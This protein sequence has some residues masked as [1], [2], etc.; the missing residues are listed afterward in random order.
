M[1]CSTFAL[2]ARMPDP[3]SL[4]AALHAG[5]PDLRVDRAGQGAVVRLCTEEGRQ[6]VAV[7]APRYLQVP[8]EA[9]RLLGPAAATESPVWWTEVRAASAVP[10]A[11]RLSASVA[12]RL[13]SLLD[14]TT[15]PRETAAHTDVVTV[16]ASGEPAPALA[17][18]D[19][20]LTEAD[21]LTDR[22]AIVLPDI[23]VL[24]ATTWLTELLRT[25]ARTGRHLYLVTPP[26]TRLTLPARTLLDRAP[27]RWVVRDPGTG[28][29]D[30]LT[31]LEL[32][33]HG[34]HFAPPAGRNPTVVD[35]YR[36]PPTG[37][38]GERQFLLSARTIHPAD[39]QLLLGGTLECAWQTLTG[40]PPAGW[41]TAEP[42]NVPWSRRQLTDLARSRA[43]RGS[44][45]WL[46]AV[47]SPGRPAIAT[48]WV[49]HT[50]LGVEE[51]ITLALGHTADS[52]VPLDRLPH[53]AEVLAAQH[54]LATM[55]TEV[56]AARADLMA[57]AHYEPPALPVSLTF[58]PD[59][60]ADTGLSRVEEALPDTPVVRLGPTAR[61]TL[62]CTLGDGTDPAAWRR[63]RRAT[64]HL[65]VAPATQA[66]LG[67]PGG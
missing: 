22:A 28:Y 13:A 31:G 63:L 41:S 12:G 49:T 42:V 17:A 21:M 11:P 44:P 33:W 20:V 58:G 67:R 16:E 60:V 6:V 23:P 64:A 9:A 56:R 37:R 52:P 29:Y 66:V 2:T 40:E 15:W 3:V 34:D 38:S 14:G 62:H 19:D 48:Q 53:L 1:P 55:V 18:G 8:G 47:G 36:P 54:H 24:A 25:T 51:H 27:A 32:V 30:G 61:P 10:E 57:P 35:A 7:E 46:V 65:H 5:G 43:R 45:T 4:L 50:R 26:T 59:T 39:E